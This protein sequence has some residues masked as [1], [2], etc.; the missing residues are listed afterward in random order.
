MSLMKKK[1]DMKKLLE[2]EL[3]KLESI[4]ENY[5]NSDILRRKAY[6]SL[7][8]EEAKN[9]QSTLEEAEKY[10]EDIS[11]YTKKYEE[12]NNRFKRLKTLDHI[13]SFGAVV[14]FL[15]LLFRKVF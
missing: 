14:S 10:G 15:S 11:P 3:Q 4:V 7:F 9:F 1:I 13:E 5:K 12:I 6:V 2:K 8:Y